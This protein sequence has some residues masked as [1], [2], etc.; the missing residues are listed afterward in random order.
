MGIWTNFKE[1]L[2]T[3]LMSNQLSKSE[4]VWD[5]TWIYLSDDTLHQQRLLLQLNGNLYTLI[6]CNFI[7]FSSLY[8]HFFIFVYSYIYFYIFTYLTLTDEHLKSLTLAEVENLM[9]SNNRSLLEFPSMPRP[10]MSSIPGS[11]NRLLYDELKYDRVSLTEEDLQLLPTMNKRRPMAPLRN[12]WLKIVEGSF[13]FMALF[14]G[15][16]KTFLWRGTSASLRSKSEI[17]LTVASSIIAALLI[18]GGRIEH[19]RF[20]ISLNVNENS[21]C[22]IKQGSNLDELIIRFI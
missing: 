15:T 6:F 3:L 2:A 11:Q 1:I 14:G 18:L 19:S 22:N 16:G 7:T 13:F 4:V 8:I 9:L 12:V 20:Q 17:I 5:S 10:D 21:T